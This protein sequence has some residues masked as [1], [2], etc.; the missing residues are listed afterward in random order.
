ME[1]KQ[2]KIKIL[3]LFFLIWKPIGIQWDSETDKDIITKCSSRDFLVCTFQH[4]VNLHHLPSFPWHFSFQQ[5]IV[6]D[7]ILRSRSNK[8]RK[9]PLFNTRY[10]P[11]K[12]L[13]LIEKTFR[14]ARLFLNL[15]L[16]FQIDCWLN[17]M[18]PS[19]LLD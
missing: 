8:R 19:S 1:K 5:T 2:I 3:W 18:S 10:R 6:T 13:W 16:I 17:L 12:T 9:H 4:W 11:W 7:K 14:C 15:E